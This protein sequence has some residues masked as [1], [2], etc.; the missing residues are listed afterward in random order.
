MK[1]KS[2]LLILLSLY[3]A[4]LYSASAGLCQPAKVKSEGGKQMKTQ[5]AIFGAGCFWGVEESFRQLPG[6][7]STAAGFCGGNVENPTY[8]RVCQGN[9][10]HAEVVEIIFDP[11]KIS[12]TNLL[13]KFFEVH[14]PTTM[15]RQGLDIG[16]QYRSVIFFT[17]PEQE[18]EAKTV[19]EEWQKVHGKTAV[20][21]IEPAKPF[22]KAEEYHQ[23]YLQK[24][25]LGV[26]H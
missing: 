18:K 19:K 15:N 1:R 10:K 6:V 14:D 25:G 2:L 5:K 16:E 23:K 26:C 22:Y 17:S 12:Y 11:Q 20:T 7:I 4:L 8:E 13:E 3:S 24:R 9:T 21:L